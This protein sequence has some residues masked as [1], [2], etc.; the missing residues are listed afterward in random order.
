MDPLL[1]P[2][3]MWAQRL[4]PGLLGFVCLV[5]Y[6]LANPD[7]F[8]KWAALLWKVL[9]K[10]GCLFR[11]AS[12]QAIKFDL[13]SKVNRFVQRLARQAPYLAGMRFKVEWVGNDVTRKGF[14]E[15]GQVIL[16]LRRDDPQNLNLV[17]AVYLFV[18][19]GLL[20]KL[21]RYISPAQRLAVD[22]YVTTQLLSDEK[23]EVVGAFVD[24]YLHPH[25]E[26][27]SGKVNTYYDA[28]SRI[29]RAGFL[30]PVLFQEL[31][32]LGDKV[33]GGRRSDRVIIEVDQL[34]RF[35][36]CL[37]SR[38]IGDNKP[39]TKFEGSYC[40]CAMIIVGKPM[41]VTE[42]GG[43]WIRYIRSQLI[44]N[45]IETLYLAG[46]LKNQA[47]IDRV[48]SAIGNQY[49]VVRTSKAVVPLKRPDGTT[50]IIK[51]YLSV[52]R[53]RGANVFQPSS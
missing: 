47:V 2:V 32:F 21:K 42:E 22:L 31:A 29:D 44:P 30:Y 25:M 4:A 40:R 19:V 5:V 50:V 12:K 46:P 24:E 52:L 53:K 34:M 1:K 3:I 6:L 8:E 43:V 33:F 18:A 45:Q 51:Q 37:A 28:M 27:D 48:C 23:H 17:H 15:N 35:L 9:A 39:D 13:Q 49:D 26:N 16:R 11:S 38:S 41:N 14:L 36:E 7:K 10:F 20:S